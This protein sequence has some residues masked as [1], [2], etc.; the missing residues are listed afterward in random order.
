MG[1]G[2]LTCQRL[3]IIS[4]DD[5]ETTLNLEDARLSG[6][7]ERTKQ[8]CDRD[9]A[10]PVQMSYVEKDARSVFLTNMSHELMVPLNYRNN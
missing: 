8:H 3:V 9:L 4:M 10:N 1:S 6:G 5:K 2:N 7:L